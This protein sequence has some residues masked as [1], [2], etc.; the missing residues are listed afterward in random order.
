MT[1]SPRDY[2]ETSSFVT[3]ISDHATHDGGAPDL[4]RVITKLTKINAALMQR[5][6]RSMDQQANA[7]SLFQTAISQEA[8]IRARTEELNHA[9]SNLAHANNELR[10]ARD[11]AERANLFKTRFFTAVGHD[12]LQPLHAARLTLSE[13]SDSQVEPNNA[14]MTANISHALSTIEELLT[15]ILDISKLEAGVFLPNIQTVALGDVFARLVASLDPLARRK[16]LALRCRATNLCVRSDPL[17]LRRILQNLLVNAA[18]Y[19]DK[20]GLLLSARQRGPRVA[21]EVWDTGSGIAP[22]ERD[23]IFEEF[24]RG[25]ASERSGG[26]GFGLGLA[27]VKR[28][29][30]ALEHP[31]ELRSRPGR[32]SR[33]TVLAPFAAAQATNMPSPQRFEPDT[34]GL[35]S[36]PLIVIDN[37]LTVLDAMH[38]LLGRWG[39]DVRLARDLDDISEILSDPSFDPALILADY[40]LDN[41]VIGIDAVARVRDLRNRQIPAILITADRAEATVIAAMTNGCELLHKPV[42]PAELRAL[43]Q[44]LLK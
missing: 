44:H 36:Q 40:H 11:A 38:T 1:S 42:R 37:D 34:P 19:T 8:Q 24:Q 41:G 14:R 7:F 16:N 22:T 5:V 26:V 6:E 2:L 21:I 23:R 28:M 10:A 32:G 4:T 20:G 29:T 25:T 15:S 18:N 35:L 33:F 9:L 27:I 3:R 30:E 31:L 12:L 17:M 13:L 39:A 43:M